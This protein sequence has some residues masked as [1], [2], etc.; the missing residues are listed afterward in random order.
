MPG[1]TMLLQISKGYATRDLV[2]SENHKLGK[3]KTGYVKL[4]QGR[5]G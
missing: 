4:G 2:I 3:V 1:E 5:P